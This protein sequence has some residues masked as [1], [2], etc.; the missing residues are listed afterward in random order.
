MSGKRLKQSARA[1]AFDSTAILPH[2]RCAGLNRSADRFTTLNPG[3]RDDALK[4]SEAKQSARAVEFETCPIS[5]R[6]NHLSAFL[7]GLSVLSG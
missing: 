6:Q 4:A 1:V 5:H 7:S 2:S 3:V